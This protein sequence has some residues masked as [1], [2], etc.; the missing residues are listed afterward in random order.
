MECSHASK[1]G[2]AVGWRSPRKRQNERLKASTSRKKDFSLEVT[3]VRDSH[4]YLKRV[5][6][7]LSGGTS[8]GGAPAI[9]HGVVPRLNRPPYPDLISMYDRGNSR[10][11][12]PLPLV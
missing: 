3:A 4:R 7:R 5:T 12:S 2:H 10:A 8:G 9:K 11:P 1:L 6:E